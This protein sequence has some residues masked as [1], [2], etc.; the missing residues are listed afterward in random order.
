MKYAISLLIIIIWV[1][2]AS[3][4]IRK[5]ALAS[6]TWTT[7]NGLQSNSVYSMA[8]D[9]NGYIW[10]GTTN[11]LSRFDGYSFLRIGSV[12]TLGRGDGTEHIG[13]IYTDNANRLVWVTT[14]SSRLIC[15]NWQTMHPIDYTTS[16]DYDRIYQSFRQH[17]DGM[18]M[19]SKEFGLRHIACKDGKF[20]KYDYTAASRKLPSNT[21]NDITEDKNHSTWA[22]TTKGL[23][24]I[25]S[26]NIARTVISNRN[27]LS[28]KTW[29][30]KVFAFTSDNHLLT[31]T[32]QGRKL[33]DDILP[34][35]LGRINI[36]RVNIMWQGKWLLF[37]PD[38][39]LAYDTHN[40]TFSKPANI[41]MQKAAIQKAI[42][43]YQFVADRSG[44]LWMFPDKGDV[45]VLNLVKDAK[46]PPDKGHIFFPTIDSEGVIWIGT[47]CGGL[48]SYD[49]HNGNIE[50]YSM[51]D[52]APVID[53]NY[54]LCT[55]ADSDD[56]IWVGTEYGGISCV[57]RKGNLPGKVISLNDGTRKEWENT[58]M[59]V[60]IN[61][62]GQY[63]VSTRSDAVYSYD[64]KT[65]NVKNIG[66]LVS[67][68]KTICIDNNGNEWIGTRGNGIY[69]NGTQYSVESREHSFVSDDIYDIVCDK[70]G[71]V[72]IATWRN[73]LALCKDT[74]AR[75]LHFENFLLGDNNANR[76]HDLELSDDD[77]L[78]I[79]SSG[80]LFHVNTNL[81]EIGK[82]NIKRSVYSK[83]DANNWTIIALKKSRQD[84]LWLG[85]RDGVL[86]CKLDKGNSITDVGRID[87]ASG[88]AG[89]TIASMEEDSFGYLWVSTDNGLARINQK[90]MVADNM[91]VSDRPLENNFVS[92]ASLRLPNGRL[93]FGAINGLVI[94][95]PGKDIASITGK[96]RLD[97]TNIEVNGTSLFDGNNDGETVRNLFKSGKLSLASDERSIDIYFSNFDFKGI[98]EAVYQYYLEGV[99][100]SWRMPTTASHV[101]YNGLEPGHY[102]F[103]LRT[104]EANGWSG[105]KTL[106]INI[107]QPFYNTWLAWLIYLLVVAV[108]AYYLYHNWSVRFKL[109][110]RMYVDKELNEFRINFFTHIAHEFRTPLSIIMG[111]VRKLDEQAKASGGN[112]PAPLRTVKR[113]AQRLN[114]LV[115]ELIKFRKV[116]TDNM[117][118]HVEEGDIIEFLRNICHDFWDVS[119]QKR[120]QLIFTPFSKSYTMVFDRDAVEH[121]VYNLVSNAVK[122]TPEGGN[123]NV[124]IN[125]EQND[126][127][128][129]KVI[130]TV[131]DDGPGID[132]T[133]LSHL[134]EPFM[135]G[136]S[137]QGGMGIGLF[138]AKRMAEVHRGSLDYQKVEPHGSRFTFSL[139]AQD[140]YSN[141]E[142]LKD[143]NNDNDSQDSTEKDKMEAM[144]REI[145]P[146]AMNDITIVV[147]E[148][149]PDMVEQIKGE[150]GVYFHIEGFMNGVTGYE[151]VARIKPALVVC[152]VMLPDKNGYD[153]VRD[154][155]KNSETKGIPV[156]M[157]T[158]LDDDLH[159]MKG[160]NAGADDYMTKPCN[161]NLLVVRAAQLIKWSKEREA[162]KADESKGGTIGN[163]N[164]D[165]AV[166][167][168]KADRRFLDQLDVLIE[169]NMEDSNLTVDSLA[170]QLHYGRTTFYGKVKELTGVSPNKYLLN[171]RMQ[172]AAELLEEGQYNVS[173]VCYKVGFANTSY[174]SNKFKQYYGV[175][176]SKYNG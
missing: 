145:A 121:V 107:R 127:T 140:E 18:W 76:I 155:K 35:S 53:D 82:G 6:H 86:R 166:V 58:L 77:E 60:T 87:H 126:D 59:S 75:K 169:N 114:R 29:H 152:D 22:A 123:I 95:S 45:K 84:F 50:S 136:Y 19:W 65:D 154:I 148:D 138:M 133:Q 171:K 10:I 135:H 112:A 26:D 61:K 46:F 36:L 168:S 105:E 4:F 119:Q 66:A 129:E 12:I 25:G 118:L 124:K 88:L 34:I 104:K 5:E 97:I 17:S 156:I 48:Y 151:A 44:R 163:N 43:G 99:D 64:Y 109:R 89:N 37:S 3:A 160:Y 153:I 67:G 28:V 93:L 175:L 125:L 158:A 2:Q 57:Y 101:S 80:G 174:F 31:F 21:I 27:I 147:I 157:L 161:Y 63:V 120:Q 69:V 173:E 115:N 85:L 106:M 40:G 52:A 30:D 146:K 92:N 132:T 83:T 74:R 170:E 14:A 71:R 131:E 143:K 98:N 23:V 70:H 9:G 134:Y 176:P 73:G 116:S 110:Q 122:Y 20:S 51:F 102:I 91:W 94:V 16:G 165:D 113:S 11:G 78:W 164:I 137:S 167:I 32:L 100:G 139:P 103:H 149:D 8:Q 56:N 128:T 1:A 24:L 54:V 41:Q 47:Y 68:I 142:H 162:Q 159:Q 39:G 90:T 130:I 42:P 72:W 15:Y 79:G 108:V 172:T 81:K 49:T 150:L 144:V 33:R 96:V 7:Q 62:S 13:N 111:A 55:M 117:R 141:E 38:G